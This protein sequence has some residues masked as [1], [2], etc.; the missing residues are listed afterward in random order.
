MAGDLMSLFQSGNPF[1]IDEAYNQLGQATQK[2]AADIAQVQALTNK[3]N[4]MLPYDIEHSK[5]LTGSANAQARTQNLDSDVKGCI[6]LEERSRLYWAKH[7]SEATADQLKQLENNMEAMRVYA[8]KPSYSLE[9]QITMQKNYPGLL[10]QL[11]QPNGRKIAL[12][13][14]DD[15]VKSSAQYQTA[16]L[17]YDASIYRTDNPAPRGAGGTKYTP[18]ADLAADLAKMKR[19]SEKVAHLETKLPFMSPEEKV[20]WTPILA[21]LKQQA[22]VERSD[23]SAGKF[24]IID[25]KPVRKPAAK[26][27]GQGEAKPLPALPPGFKLDN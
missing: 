13:A 5:A 7:R 10:E 8:L 6:P 4:T 25:G 27:T 11:S 12:K 16:K 22:D 24:E 20:M 23:P 17:G 26:L 3:T 14:Y 21:T 9:D 18:G 2:N 1:L 19:A 15:Y